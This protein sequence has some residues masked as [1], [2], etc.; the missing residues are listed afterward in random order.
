MPTFV[1]LLV[2]SEAK[3]MM[4]LGIDL[5][6]HDLWIVPPHWQFFHVYG[7]PVLDLLTESLFLR[8]I[9]QNP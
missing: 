4:L 2:P 9:G 1:E 7:Q 8:R 3:L 6:T 5:R